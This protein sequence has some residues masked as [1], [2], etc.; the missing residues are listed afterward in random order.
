MRI[1]VTRIRPSGYAVARGG[2]TDLGCTPK[3]KAVVTH[4]LFILNA[5]QKA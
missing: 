5:K 4:R 2:D 3:E 1:P